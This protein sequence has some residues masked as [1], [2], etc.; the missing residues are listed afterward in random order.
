M[1]SSAS[2][3]VSFRKF[4]SAAALPS[5]MGYAA[6]N[7]L[8]CSSVALDLAA[9][10]FLSGS[11]GPAEEGLQSVFFDRG[12]APP[13]GASSENKVADA[14]ASAPERVFSSGSSLQVTVTRPLSRSAARPLS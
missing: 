12:G 8:N 5:R 4:L 1:A 2:A 3:C 7:W 14:G 9:A 10:R 13:V 11:V 6:Q